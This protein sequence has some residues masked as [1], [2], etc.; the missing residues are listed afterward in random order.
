MAIERTFYCDRDGCQRH[1]RTARHRPFEG[2]GFLT[3][4]GYGRPL[5]FCGWD[6]VLKHAAT[7]EPETIIPMEES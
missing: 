3:I 4:T 5:H 1:V 7:F 6:C 2:T